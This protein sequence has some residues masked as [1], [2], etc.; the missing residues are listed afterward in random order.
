MTTLA[1]VSRPR[2]GRILPRPRLFRLLDTRRPLAW[3][4]GPPGAGKTALVSG[5]LDARRRRALWYQC[6]SGDTSVAGFLEYLAL[7]AGGGQRRVRAAVAGAGAR[8]VAA[9]VG[10]ILRSFDTTTPAPRS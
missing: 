3:V 1:K 2:L 7:A 9:Q 5:W 10:A 6:D 4:W 8:E